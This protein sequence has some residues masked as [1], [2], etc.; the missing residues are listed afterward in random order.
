MTTSTAN[1]A[2]AKFLHSHHVWTPQQLTL[3]ANELKIADYIVDGLI[4]QQGISIAVGSGLGKSPLQY[5]AGICV[6]AGEP[7]LGRKVQRGRVLYIDYEN[8]LAQVDGL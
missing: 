7:F 4:P 1:D 6:A 2:Q 3:R 8:G 5:Q